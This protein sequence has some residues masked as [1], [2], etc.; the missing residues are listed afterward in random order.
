MIDFGLTKRYRKRKDGQHI[1]FDE[2]KPLTGTVRYLGLNAH[3]GYELSRRDDLEAVGN[4]ILYFYLGR[5]P[6]QDVPQEIPF[7]ERI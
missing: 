7:N 5:L 3:R 2:N 6:W 1:P 4:M